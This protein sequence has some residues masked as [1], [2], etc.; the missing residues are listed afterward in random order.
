LRQQSGFSAAADHVRES[1]Q[2]TLILNC[3]SDFAV[4]RSLAKS[5][6]AIVLSAV[7][8]SFPQMQKQVLREP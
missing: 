3:L 5:D 4:D 7:A 1:I 8:N 2:L 6:T